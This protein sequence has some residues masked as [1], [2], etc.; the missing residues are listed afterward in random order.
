MKFIS[1]KNSRGFTLIELL[2]VIAI[3]S[4]L[5]SVIMVSINNARI[6]A[7]DARRMSDLKEIKTALELYY[8]AK[9]YYPASDCGWDCNGYR[10]SYSAASWNVLKAE[11]APYINLPVDPINSG[12]SPWYGGYT[13]AYGNVGR[14]VYRP[15]YDLTAAFENPKNPNRCEVKNYY[16]YFNNYYPW[17]GGYSPLLYEASER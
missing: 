13:Y 1:H 4:L 10:V 3:I 7:R 2:V 5:S 12:D 6:R 17:C 16:F 14:T 8:N 15:Q 9:G 11:L